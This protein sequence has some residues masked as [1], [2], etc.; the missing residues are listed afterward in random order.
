MVRKVRLFIFMM[1]ALLAVYLLAIGI[2]YHWPPVLVMSAER[3]AGAGETLLVAGLSVQAPVYVRLS[4]VAAQ[5]GAVPLSAEAVGPS[6]GRTPLAGSKVPATEEGHGVRLSWALD[7]QL[8]ETVIIKYRYLGWPFQAEVSGS[9]PAAAQPAAAM[10]PAPRPGTVLYRLCAEGEPATA[11][12]RAAAQQEVTAAV[13][14]LTDASALQQRLLNLTGAKSQPLALRAD[15]DGDGAL[16]TLVAF[17]F[18][19]MPALLYRSAEFDRPIPLPAA[20]NFTWNYDGGAR[21]DQIADVNADGKPEVV[22]EITSAGASSIKTHLYVYQWGQGFVFS[23]LLSNWRGPNQWT[24]GDGTISI[25]C[26]PIGPFEYKMALSRQQTEKFRWNPATSRY[27]LT[28]RS[29]EPVQ[30][31]LQQVSDAEELFQIGGYDDALLAYS[32]VGRF[33]PLPDAEADWPAFAAMRIGQIHALAGRRVEALE[34]LERASE[35]AGVVG[36]LA[37]VFRD[38]YRSGDAADA[39]AAAWR[40]VQANRYRDDWPFMLDL[41]TLG[42]RRPMV[43]AF[44]AAGRPEPAGLPEATDYKPPTC[45]TID[46]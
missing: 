3:S 12:L 38:A 43:D 32:Q 18:C 14:A 36:A 9:W 4:G 1:V 35:G 27:E 30:T 24:V 21:V 26:R 5:G 37:G 17:G 41:P 6:G 16:D 10:A 20:E 46:Y 31:Q 34:A 25:Q 2:A 22:V 15:A 42:A 29:R 44:R 45:L 39:F 11:E 8:P 28:D 7:A 13:Q 19:H 33:K 40:W 23:D